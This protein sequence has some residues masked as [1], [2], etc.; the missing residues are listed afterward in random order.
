MSAMLHSLLH[1]L[2]T[3]PGLIANHA[4]AY[5]ELIG[6]EIGAMSSAYERRVVLSASQL[7]CWTAAA[8]LA[9]VALML[10]S[11]IP[12]PSAKALWIGICMP[13]VAVAAALWCRMAL[14]MNKDSRPFECVRQ[15]LKEDAMM[16][17]EAGVL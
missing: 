14:Q 1:L 10:W 13:L 7:C 9:G 8:I 16:L 6:A 2:A 17:R 4:D 12:E 11:V 5:A 15:Q 3:Q